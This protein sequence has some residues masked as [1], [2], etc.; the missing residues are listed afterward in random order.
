MH[1]TNSEDVLLS[2]MSDLLIQCGMQV[3]RDNEDSVLSAK[4][5]TLCRCSERHAGLV[6]VVSCVLRTPNPAGEEGFPGDC[7]V[8]QAG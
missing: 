1:I 7:A 6:H 4:Q 8:S 5:N 2:F 3:K